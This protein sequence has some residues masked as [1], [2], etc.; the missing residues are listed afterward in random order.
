MELF[1]KCSR[2][3]RLIEQYGRRLFP[4]FVCCLLGEDG[5]FER[6][7]DLTDMDK[8]FYGRDTANESHA[9]CPTCIDGL[10]KWL[11]CSEDVTSDDEV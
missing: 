4:G 7:P 2:C 3:G 5:R 11:D 10:L 1:T 6:R 9:L 8:L